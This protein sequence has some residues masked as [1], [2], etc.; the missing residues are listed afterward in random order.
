MASKGPPAAYVE[1]YDEDS[2]APL[3]GTRLSAN[4]APNSAVKLSRLDPRI[5]EPLIDGASDSGY[6]SRT[7]ATIN[8]TQSD[9]SGGKSHPSPL[10]LENPKRTDLNRKTSTRY[11]RDPE[12]SRPSREEKMVGA[13]SGAAHHAHAHRSSSKPRRQERPRQYHDSYYD[14]SGGYHPSTPMDHRPGEYPYYVQQRPPVPDF[15]SSPHPT[16]YPRAVE[17]IHVSHSGRPHRSHS[18][19]TYH[20]N[21]R[22]MSFHGGMPPGMGSGMTSPMYSQSSMQGYDPGHPPTSYMP[23]QYSSSPYGQSSYY[24]PSASEY[25]P[26]S[27][28]TRE[29][30][31]SREPSRRRSASTYGP[32]QPPPME[33]EAYWY[34]E[35]HPLERYSS[36]EV[37]GRPS[38]SHQEQDED[39]YRMP[40]PPP[41]PPPPPMAKPKPRSNPQ[42]HQVKRPERPEARK[43][44]TS[45]ATVPSQRRTSR[46]M[47]GDYDPMDMPDLRDALPVVPDRRHRR[48]SRDAPLPERTHSLRDTRRSTSYQDE[49][50]SAQIAVASSRRR[51]PTEYYYEP[52]STAED[53]EDRENEVEAYQAEARASRQSAATLPLSQDVLPA[54][55]SNRNGSDSG[56]QKSRS[57]SSRGSGTGSRTEEDKNMTLTLNGLKIGFTQEALAGKSVNIR[58][59]ETGAVRLNIGGNLRQP[60]QYVNGTGSDYAGGSSRREIEDGR[61]PRGD[62]RSGASRRDSQS[63]Y[64]GR[65]HH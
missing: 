8:S 53:L 2:N 32:P 23:S 34:E 57:N 4:I 13:F 12:Q 24:A 58:A 55:T 5:P 48:M 1:E 39:Y 43:M 33:S 20:S 65:Y 14:Y 49:R 36:R 63:A 26:P 59:G 64:T 52:S 60:K 19:N 28:Y 6:S 47:G 29:R 41:P 3:P 54:K 45:A 17:N 44:H 11:R 61:R 27:D 16:Q 40:P 35:D 51:K 31:Q 18:Y 42:V 22:P 38:T 56:S 9:P 62:R 21:G 37:R 7:A 46:V 15:A 30:S 25:G 10:K 50:R